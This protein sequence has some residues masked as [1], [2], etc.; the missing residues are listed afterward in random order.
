MRKIRLVFCGYK[1]P[2][3]DIFKASDF[4]SQI[5]NENIFTNL[6]EAVKF[7]GESRV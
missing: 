4:I 3:R 1:G 6:P 7:C 2:V 5:R